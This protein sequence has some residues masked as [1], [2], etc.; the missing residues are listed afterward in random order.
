MPNQSS[1]HPLSPARLEQL[2]SEKKLL[3]ILQPELKQKVAQANPQGPYI[4]CN[5]SHLYFSLEHIGDPKRREQ[6]YHL[7]QRHQVGDVINQAAIPIEFQPFFDDRWTNRTI[8]WLALIIGGA[9]GIIMGVLAMAIGTLFLNMTA[10][11]LGREAF[12]P[13]GVQI[14]A[15]IF[16]LFA[17]VGWLVTSLITWHKLV[18]AKDMP[19]Y[20]TNSPFI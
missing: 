19:A 8:F 15:V 17:A 7:I 10:I 11:T 6:V 5:E 12:D 13:T 20:G 4:V 16:V 2:I 14:T 9:G 1:Q 3:R 18:K